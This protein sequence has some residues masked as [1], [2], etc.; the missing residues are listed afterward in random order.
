VVVGVNKYVDT[1]QDQP[2]EVHKVDPESEARQVSHLKQVKAN[3]DQDAVARSLAAL[4]ATALDPAANLMPA[5][6]EAVK[7]HASMGEIVNELKGVFGTY[8]EIPVF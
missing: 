1:G 6:I 3:R 2:V 4:R 5:T 7:A 8:R